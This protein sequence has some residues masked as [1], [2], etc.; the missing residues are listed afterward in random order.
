MPLASHRGSSPLPLRQSPQ[1]KATISTSTP[2]NAAL[3]LALV[4]P[5]AYRWKTGNVRIS[6]ASPLLCASREEGGGIFSIIVIVVCYIM[7]SGVLTPPCRDTA[8]ER[9]Q[10]HWAD[11]LTPARGQLITSRLSVLDRL[12]S[13]NRCDRSPHRRTILSPRF[14]HMKLISQHIPIFPRCR[15][16][17]MCLPLN[18]HLWNRCITFLNKPPFQNCLGHHCLE[19]KSSSTGN[20]EKTGV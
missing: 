17:K 4:I 18:L 16:I 20:L 15:C 10:A 5:M 3:C 11:T 6:S 1:T 13:H 9:L 8:R 2:P 19:E 12:F 7:D 14:D